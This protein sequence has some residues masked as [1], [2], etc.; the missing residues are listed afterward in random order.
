MI[1]SRDIVVFGDDWGWYPSTMQHIGRVLAR[2][3]RLLWI[4]SL[5]LRKPRLSLYDGLRVFTKARGM[6][7]TTSRVSH[8]PVNVTELHPFVL[9]FH[10]QHLVR[11][12]NA[13]NLR[14]QVLAAMARLEFQNP[15][16]ITSSP[17]VSRLIGRLGESSS[18]YVCLDDFTLF[19]RAFKCIASEESLVLRRIDSCFAVSDSLVKS[20]RAH[21]GNVFF[22]PQGV[23]TNHFDR[24]VQ[25]APAVR[26]V[27]R[28]VIGFFGLLAPW[29]DLRLIIKVALAYPQTTVM[30]I[31]RSSVDMKSLQMP[32]NLLYLGEVPYED[33]PSYACSFD[34]GL[35]PFHVNDLTVAANPLKLLEYFSLGIP[36]VSTDLPEVRKFSALSSVAKDDGDFIHLVGKALAEVSTDHCAL[37][38]QEAEKFSWTKLVY[39]M[40]ERILGIDREKQQ[41]VSRVGSR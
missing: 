13:Y 35:I 32:P 5:G 7:G 27:S 11:E 24:S 28:P 17:I 9:P 34:V 21:N 33:L 6:L 1:H 22:L 23:D 41:E 29:V 12:F 30:L 36:V 37:R 26:Q 39:E 15:L 38:R 8:A 25:A 14:R 4:G 40:S 31:G 10:D 16:F 19:D 18:H 3:N 2:S 20:R